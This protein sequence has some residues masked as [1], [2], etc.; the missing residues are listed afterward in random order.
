MKRA[1][2]VPL[3]RELHAFRRVLHELA[4]SKITPQQVLQAAPELAQGTR[5][6]LSSVAARLRA[7][8]LVQPSHS[9]LRLLKHMPRVFEV[10][11]ANVPQWVRH[12]G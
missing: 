5:V 12:T 7:C 10:Q 6:S 1:S 11:S 9:A 3:L 8:G 4:Y 2:G